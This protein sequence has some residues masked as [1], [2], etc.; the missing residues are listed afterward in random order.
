MPWI[1]WVL[2]CFQEPGGRGDGVYNMN[3]RG[4][5]SVRQDA[6]EREALRRSVVGPDKVSAATARRAAQAFSEK[7]FVNRFNR[8][9]HAMA[10][11][12]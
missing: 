2:L 10:D 12:E 1:L 5:E 11:F 9:M 7:E 3:L 8:V 6:F 4:L